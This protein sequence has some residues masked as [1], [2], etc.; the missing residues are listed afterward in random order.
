MVHIS[1]CAFYSL[2][3]AIEPM[4]TFSASRGSIFCIGRTT[5]GGDH[6]PPAPP[7]LI[8]HPYIYDSNSLGEVSALS[9]F[10]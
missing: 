2:E 10:V 5:M 8:T 7:A 6:L 4:V 9:P 1:G 3:F